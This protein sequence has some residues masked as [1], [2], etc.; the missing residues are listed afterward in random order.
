MKGL[1]FIKDPDGN[2]IEILSGAGLRD[3]VVKLSP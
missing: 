2:W 3:I 1:A